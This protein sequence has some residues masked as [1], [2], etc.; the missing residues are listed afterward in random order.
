MHPGG[1]LRVCQPENGIFV[2]PLCCLTET[3]WLRQGPL[4]TTLCAGAGSGS[5]CGGHAGLLPAE[6]P[7]PHR[8][9]RARGGRRLSVL[10][11][12]RLGGHRALPHGRLCC[13]AVPA[14]A[15]G[16]CGRPGRLPVFQGMLKPAALPLRMLLL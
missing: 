2:D 5:A 15:A 7:H 8:D 11:N 9:S 14:H 6:G 12:G 4:I 16:Q 3:A 1:M 10:R 13:A